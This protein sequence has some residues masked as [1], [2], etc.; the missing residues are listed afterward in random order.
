MHC[1]H[2]S[3]ECVHSQSRLMEYAEPCPVKLEMSYFLA[4]CS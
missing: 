2:F 4:L 3:L 1:L